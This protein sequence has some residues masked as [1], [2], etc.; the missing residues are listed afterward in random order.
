M[1]LFDSM[2]NYAH[3]SEL[4]ESKDEIIC[5]ELVRGLTH[6]GW[7]CHRIVA[8]SGRQMMGFKVPGDPVLSAVYLLVDRKTGSGAISQSM[9][10]KTVI[11]FTAETRNKVSD[12]DDLAK[13]WRT[14]FANFFKVPV[15]G[16]VRVNH[17]LNTIN[18]K[19]FYMVDLDQY[20]SGS[21]VNAGPL[22]DW[23][24]GQ[25]DN[26]REHLRPHKK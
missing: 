15:S 10:S 18:A 17:Q 4:R 3:K 21:A 20:V 11:G 12:P 26:L 22:V 16:E 13:M 9:G 8:N 14:D 5:G 24:A 2:T 19:T 1:G 6:R 23:V 7:N 25:V